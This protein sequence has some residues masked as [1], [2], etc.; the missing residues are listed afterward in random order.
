MDT[1]TY[2]VLKGRSP[3]PFGLV[4]VSMALGLP[5]LMNLLNFKKQVTT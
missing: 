1:Q 2:F 3:S 4:Y 5:L